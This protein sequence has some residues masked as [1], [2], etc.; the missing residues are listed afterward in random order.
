MASVWNESLLRMIGRWGLAL[1]MLLVLFVFS[2]APL[3][4]ARLGEI[5]PVFMLMAVYYWTILRPALLPAPAVFAI[6]LVLDLLSAAPFGMNALILVLAQWLIRSQ[7]K[8]LLGQS[9]L[10][11]WAGF[12]AIATGAGLMQWGL[13]VMFNLTLFSAKPMLVSVVIST[14]LFPLFVWPL[15][16][17]HKALMTHSSPTS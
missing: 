7:R 11:I 3:E 10:M 1:A 17:V 4:I 8:F 16:A 14:L 9:F 5:R 2:A 13:F 12:A 6:G 15:S